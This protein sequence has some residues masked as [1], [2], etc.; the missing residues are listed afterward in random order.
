[1][2]LKEDAPRGRWWEGGKMVAPQQA[3]EGE[4]HE[5]RMR[6]ARRLTAKLLLGREIL[7]PEVPPVPGWQRWMMVGWVAVGAGAYFSM[8]AGWWR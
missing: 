8:L 4:L 7:K 3:R 2:P 6:E 5:Q 1:M